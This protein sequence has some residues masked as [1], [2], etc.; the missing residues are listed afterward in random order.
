MK[1][2]LFTAILL[3]SIFTNGCKKEDTTE[4]QPKGAYGNANMV[5][6]GTYNP[7]NWFSVSNDGTNFEFTAT[8]SCADVTQTVKD[9][10]IVMVY[11]DDGSGNWLAL[12]F[13]DNSSGA[14]GHSIKF[15]YYFSVGIVTLVYE[16]FDN[17]G[18]PTVNDLNGTLPVRVV[19]ISQ[20]SKLANPNVDYNNYAEVREVFHLQQ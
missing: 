9:K 6:S 17:A 14:N 1:T 19:T 13:T 16:G 2:K 15:G 11:G 7:T 12:P 10:G 3:L 20:A 5:T 4:Y 8:V 18:S